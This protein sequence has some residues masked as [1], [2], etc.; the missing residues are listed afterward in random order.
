MSEEGSS[1]PE[2][3]ALKGMTAPAPVDNFVCFPEI[4][5]HFIGALFHKEGMVLFQYLGYV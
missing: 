4:F 5:Q 1:V 2:H 3:E